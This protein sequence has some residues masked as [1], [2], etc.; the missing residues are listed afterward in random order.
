MRAIFPGNRLLRKKISL[1]RKR[2]VVAQFRIRRVWEDRKIVLAFRIY[3]TL[4][5][6]QKIV[7]GP[8]T[9]TSF[10]VR[11]DIG[12]VVGTERGLNS[13]SPREQ[14]A[15]RFFVGVA[16]HTTSGVRKVA[17]SCD[18]RVIGIRTCGRQGGELRCDQNHG[19]GI[20]N[21]RQDGS[22]QITKIIQGVKFKD[23]EKLT[24]R[25]A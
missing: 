17:A 8:F 5:R 13:A 18:E 23:G 7:I 9:N 14:F 4:E 16:T 19:R 24:E 3:P 2:V 12:A 10:Q 25:A 1:D 15:F 6:T 22:H 21:P 20:A 11:R